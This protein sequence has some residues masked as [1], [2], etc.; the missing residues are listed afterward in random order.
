M[1][2]EG[3]TKFRV[4]VEQRLVTSDACGTLTR[5]LQLPF[6]PYPGLD[7]DG[8]SLSDDGLHI[9]E[10]AWDVERVLFLVFLNLAEHESPLASGR[11]LWGEG[12]TF[13]PEE[14]QTGAGGSSGRRG[15]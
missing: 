11:G 2:A 12:W 15:R 5:E 3:L 6:A 13:T 8:L 4:L 9:E 10:V 1:D 7:R 14:P